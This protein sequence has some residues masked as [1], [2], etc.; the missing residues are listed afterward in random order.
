MRFLVLGDVFVTLE[1]LATLLAVVL[2]G[3][4]RRLLLART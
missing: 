4:H 3:R 1:E 2:V